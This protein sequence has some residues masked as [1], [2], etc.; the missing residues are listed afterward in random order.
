[1]KK[2]IICFAI[3]LICFLL[4]AYILCATLWMRE[5]IGII[6]YIFSVFFVGIG[7]ICMALSVGM[8]YDGIKEAEKDSELEKIM[9]SRNKN[10]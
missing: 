6:T 8:V 4:F 7:G 2:A 9:R 1:M 5:N 3:G 10:E